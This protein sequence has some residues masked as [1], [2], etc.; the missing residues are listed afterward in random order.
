MDNKNLKSILQE[1]LEEQIPT[2]QVN[3]LP[4][5]QAH[6]VARNKSILQQGENMNKIRNRKLALSAVAIVA[7][8]AVALITPQGRALAQSVLHFFKRSESYVIPLPPDQIVSSE[9]A[10]AIPTAAAPAQFFSVAEAEQ[11]AG[12][13]TK[14][15][16]SVPN[17]FNFTG[18]MADKGSVSIQYDVRGGGGA[19]IINESTN[20]FMESEWNQAPAE[21]IL[22]VQVGNLDAEIVQGTYV[23]YAGETS[24][25]WNPD[26]PTLRL[27]WIENGI[28]FE[29]AKLGGV[30]SIAYLDQAGLIALAE[31]MR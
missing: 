11:I 14:E 15:L 18:A 6:L 10:Q 19:L 28:W 20:G 30:E 9:E 24:A 7:L 5:V 31:S 27:R 2:S 8:L 23:V 16:S 17:G 3:L 21:F 29:M 25:K 12:F 1:A 13:D 26:A 4:N 22:Q